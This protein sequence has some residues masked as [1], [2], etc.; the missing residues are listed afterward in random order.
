MELCVS[1]LRQLCSPER[2]W[3]HPP[4][5]QRLLSFWEGVGFLWRCVLL[6]DLKESGFCSQLCC[7]LRFSTCSRDERKDSASGSALNIGTEFPPLSI[8]LS[9]FYCYISIPGSTAN[10]SLGPVSQGLSSCLPEP[11]EL[12]FWRYPGAGTPGTAPPD[13]GLGVCQGLTMAPCVL[14][15]NPFA[16]KQ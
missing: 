4:G 14:P 13:C 5:S 2:R 12:P 16:L 7:P 3:L 6:R 9:L 15:E 8:S 11:Q 10:T 1:F